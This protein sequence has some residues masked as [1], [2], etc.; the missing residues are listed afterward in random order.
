MLAMITKI[1]F[2][3]E[4]TMVTK[5]MKVMMVFKVTGNHV[6]MLS[7]SIMG[8]DVI[9]DHLPTSVI[10]GPIVLVLPIV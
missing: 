5:V 4:V 1:T 9:I 8:N 10:S 6:M 7:W 3:S 2:V